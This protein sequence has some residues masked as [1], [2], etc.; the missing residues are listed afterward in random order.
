MDMP[1]VM[2]GP[3]QEFSVSY[4]AGEGRKMVR[5]TGVLP[6]PS[7]TSGQP[8]KQRQSLRHRRPPRPLPVAS[9][10]STP[11]T[12]PHRPLDTFERSTPRSQSTT[13]GLY[14]AKRAGLRTVSI[15]AVAA[16]MPAASTVTLGESEHDTETTAGF[17]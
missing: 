7:A 9:H 12:A 5:Q 14:Q 13:A 17:A 8:R 6:T 16:A 4:H 1:L 15:S 10:E 3:S 2:I 11:P